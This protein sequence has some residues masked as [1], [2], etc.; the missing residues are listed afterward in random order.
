[1]KILLT[2]LNS[3][4]IHTSLSL[5]YLYNHTKEEFSEIKIDEFTINHNK[6]YILGEIYKGQYDII[7]FSCY[8][9]NISYTLEIIQNLKKISP[10]CTIILGGPEVSFDPEETMEKNSSI[11]YIIVGE[12]EITFKELLQYLTN[13]EGAVSNIA[14]LVYR[15]ES[16]IKRNRERKLIQNL[17][18]IT[19]PY[20][21]S[22]KD[23][24]NKIIYYESSRGCPYNCKYCLS[25]TIKGVRFFPI[26]RVK[27]DMDR[28]LDNKVKQV[29][30]VDRTFNVKKS[31]SLEIMKYLAEKDNGFTNFHFEITADLLD[32]EVLEFLSTVR[33]GLFQFEVGVQTTYDETMKSID[34]HV[35]FNIL[36]ETVKR[37]SS[38]RNIHLHLDLIAG[39]PYETF[40]RFK[41]SFDDVCYLKPEKVQ[42]G[43]LKLLKGSAIRREVEEHE[44]IF[45]EKPPYEVL[46][47]KYLSYSEIVKLKLIEEMV[48]IY[49]NSHAFNRTIEYTITNF[50]N[51][52]SEFFET[53]ASY[54]QEKGYHHLSHSK[55]RIYKIL[56]EFLK[57]KVE[58]SYKIVYDFI[59]FDYLSQGKSSLP[60]FLRSTPK[61][62]EQ[63]K[64]HEFL[65]D[66]DNIKTYLSQY[67]GIPAKQIIKKIHIENF[68]YNVL[69][70][71]SSKIG[72]SDHIVT[73][74][75][76]YDMANKIFSKSKIY[77]I[78]L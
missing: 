45:D 43:F 4:Y 53:L 27:K 58:D 76:D 42:L 72:E 8:I 17:G 19:S 50:F 22:L 78:E 71:S 75:F 49:Y 35:D 30:F 77:L 65:Q 54:W 13:P 24:E 29:K 51:S 3:K 64:V 20:E 11:D 47:N 9:W 7:C 26:D 69:E 31:H 25:S 1:M 60:D 14:G 57:V 21:G 28:F 52:P 55:N 23:Y 59:K 6:D 46:G 56:L 5:Q 44:Y 18:M 61:P 62:I 48:E 73:L 66:T 32:D 16:M 40:E 63:N 38:F 67:E 74:L 2:T 36:S 70:L 37:I 34:R 15:Q 68:R 12:G 39:L 41:T 33:E 10:N